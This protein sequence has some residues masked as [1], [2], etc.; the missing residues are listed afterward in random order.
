MLY[1]P[2]SNGK[3]NPGGKVFLRATVAAHAFLAPGFRN[4]EKR[5]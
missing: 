2:Q 1:P 4:V 5:N 3:E